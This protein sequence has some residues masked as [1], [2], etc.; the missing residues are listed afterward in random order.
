LG[1]I[2]EIL[3]GC[4]FLFLVFFSRQWLTAIAHKVSG[5]L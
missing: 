1:L 5:F 4:C 2:Q 3:C